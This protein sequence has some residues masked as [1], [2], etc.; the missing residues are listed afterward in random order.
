MCVLKHFRPLHAD[1]GQFIDIKKAPIID[2]FGCNPPIG[3]SIGLRLDELVQL[4]ETVG[5]TRSPIESSNR[6]IDGR[7]Y[8]RAGVIERRNAPLDDLLFSSA[9]NH[10]F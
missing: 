4:V 9:L 6:L 7:S 2:F 3:E 8:M 1:G 5:V 10:F